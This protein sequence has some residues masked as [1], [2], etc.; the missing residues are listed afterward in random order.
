MVHPSTI[1]H[2]G[3]VAGEAGDISLAGD[4]SQTPME[5]PTTLAGFKPLVAVYD[6]GSG[7]TA[8]LSKH[9]ETDILLV[10]DNGQKTWKSVLDFTGDT[11]GF[12]AKYESAYPQDAGADIETIKV[13]HSINVARHAAKLH[14]MYA[15]KQSSIKDSWLDTY[16]ATVCYWAYRVMTTTP[17]C[18]SQFKPLEV[19]L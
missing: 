8:K 13:R 3:D 14:D 6:I 15:V 10:L 9:N 19:D 1:R 5:V 2:T 11:S 4:L 7:W 18:A 12:R 17:V 16:A